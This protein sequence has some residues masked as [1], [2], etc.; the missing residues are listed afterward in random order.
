[1]K[2]NP[3]WCCI[4]AGNCLFAKGVNHSSATKK[5]SDSKNQVREWRKAEARLNE[6]AVA[7]KAVFKQEYNDMVATENMEALFGESYEEDFKLSKFGQRANNQTTRFQDQNLRWNS[8]ILVYGKCCFCKI[9]W[10]LFSEI[11][12]QKSL[13]TFVKAMMLNESS[14]Y[15]RLHF[16]ISYLIY[17]QLPLRP[18]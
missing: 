17:I 12:F 1:M 3:I 14:K 15:I 2:T 9:Y 7:N 10:V 6:N 11:V 13:F 18:H 5:F 16:H 4:Q 8:W